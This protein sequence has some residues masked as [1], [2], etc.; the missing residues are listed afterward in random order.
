MIQSFYLS[1]LLKAWLIRSSI[2]CFLFTPLAS[3]NIGYIL[4]AVKPGSVLISLNTTVPSA[5]TKK[6]TRD[7]P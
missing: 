4:M 1:Y 5:F 7:K 3:H 2:S 6:S